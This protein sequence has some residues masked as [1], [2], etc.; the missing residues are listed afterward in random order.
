VLQGG[1]ISILAK[2]FISAPPYMGGITTPINLLCVK[3][4][5]YALYT[6][7]ICLF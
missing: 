4:G 6:A 3:G 5:L 2:P 1:L 7:V